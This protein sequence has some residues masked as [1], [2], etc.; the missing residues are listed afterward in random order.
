MIPGTSIHVGKPDCRSRKI[1]LRCFIVACFLFLWRAVIKEVSC[2]WIFVLF[3]VVIRGIAINAGLP[4]SKLFLFLFLHPFFLFSME[5]TSRVGCHRSIDDSRRLIFDFFMEIFTNQIFFSFYQLM[6]TLMEVAWPAIRSLPAIPLSTLDIYSS[7]CRIVALPSTD[8][9]RSHHIVRRGYFSNL[10]SRRSLPDRLL[11]SLA[12]SVRGNS[13][14]RW[15]PRGW[16]LCFLFWVFTN[17]IVA[18]VVLL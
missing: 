9:L 5:V 15:L 1:M 8:V 4:G 11:Q 18:F 13:G 17:K 7:S 14:S 3:F 10:S 12:V 2:W 16:L 6:L